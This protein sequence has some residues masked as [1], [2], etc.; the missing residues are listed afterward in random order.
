MRRKVQYL[1]LEIKKIIKMFPRMLLQAILLMVLIGVIAFCGV[2]GMEREPLAVNVDIGVVVREDNTMTRMTL[3]YV[4]NMESVAQIC[5][6][7]QVSEEEGFR[8]L[9]R[10]NIAAL[11]VLPEQLVEGIMNGQNPTVDIIFPKD[12]VLEAMLFREL[13]ESGA[14]LLRVAQAQIY[15]AIDTAKE[16]GLT[17]QLS[18][19]EADIDCYNLAF[20]LDRLV[21][22]DGE[23]VSAVGRMSI[24]QYYAASG[25]VLFLLLAGMAAYPVMQQEPTVFRKQ[26]VRQGVGTLWQCLCKWLCGLTCMGLLTSAAWVLFRTAGV[27]VPESSERLMSALVGG[28]NRSPAGVQVGMILLILIVVTTFIYMIYSIAG[29]RTSS[30]LIIFL[31]SVLMVYLSGGFIPSVL[32]PQ[33]MQ[34]IGDKLPTAYLIRAFGGLLTGYA[35]ETVRQCVA[36]MCIYTVLFGTASFVIGR[37]KLR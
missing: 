2:K 31:F 26:L 17:E 15:G 21:L 8:Q 10:G 12:A 13:T 11:V 35:G 5:R 16:Y 14:G 3:N 18:A 4:Q 6:F 29:S 28:R 32:M 9:E 34:T 22:Y 1:Y 24:L 19:M 23:T 25:A 20:A 7:V 37:R 36:G 27:L 33:T 30:I